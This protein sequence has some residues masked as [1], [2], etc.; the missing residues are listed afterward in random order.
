MIHKIVSVIAGLSVVLSV[1]GAPSP[2][3]VTSGTLDR[4]KIYSPELRDSMIIDIWLPD[5]YS[6]EKQ[7]PVLYMH[8]GQNLFDASST[9]NHQAWEI[10]SVAGK[11]IS[12]GE[13]RPFIGVGIHSDQTIRVSQ[14]MPVAMLAYC[15]VA[16]TQSELFRHTD[17]IL[18][19][20]AYLNFIADYLKPYID[21]EY[22]TLP[23]A[24]NTFVMGSSMGGLMS[25]YAIC[26]RPAT[27]GGA[28]CLSTHI[29]TQ[30]TDDPWAPAVT[31]YMRDHLPD[32]LSHKLYFDTGTS[33]IDAN[34]LPYFPSLRSTAQ[35]KGYST[36]TSLET[37]TFEG[38]A[39]EEKSWAKRVEQPLRFLLGQDKNI[40]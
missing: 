1:C 10:D 6:S 27:F 28:A 25:L 17:G 37:R 3:F 34:Y 21:A 32:P 4:V 31:A 22:S 11:L 30:P 13:I 7:Y 20:D 5:G 23:D 12:S 9:W 18:R 19:G 29:A 16:P 33:T 39:H 26:Q 38:H 24:A 15:Q 8:D 35:A 2:L 40:K 14:L 36:S